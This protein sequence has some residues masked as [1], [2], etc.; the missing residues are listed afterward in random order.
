ML[1]KFSETGK[2]Q[3]LLQSRKDYARKV[4]AVDEEIGLEQRMLDEDEREERA[5]EFF[6]RRLDGGLFC[7]QMIDVIVAWLVAEDSSLKTVLQ[8]ELGGFD[9][10]RASL[11]A[12]L[13]G[14]DPTE[15]DDTR[16]MLSILIDL[17]K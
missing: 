17:V 7:L 11:Q 15:D 2:V 13:E 4:A 14:G 1:A 3:K 10:I 9:A 12:Q 16:D 5:D 6:S 8:S